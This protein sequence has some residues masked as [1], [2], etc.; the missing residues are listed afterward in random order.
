MV[1]QEELKFEPLLAAIA[2]GLCTHLVVGAAMARRLL[3]H[4]EATASAS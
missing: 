4:A 1:V 2:G 3:D